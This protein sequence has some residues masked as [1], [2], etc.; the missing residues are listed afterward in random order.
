MAYFQNPFQS[1][2]RGSWVLGDR[3]YSLTFVCPPNTGRSNE[4]VVSWN[5][6]SGTT[7]NLSGND[8]DG[9][10]KNILNIRMSVDSTFKHW[11]NLSINLT[12]NTH[13]NLNPAPNSSAITPAQIVSILNA[14]PNFSSYFKATLENSSVSQSQFKNRIG[15]RMNYESTRMKFFIINGQ[16]EE[17][18]Q[19]NNRAGVAQL[20]LY[21]SRCKIWGG[22][23]TKPSD[24]SYALVLLDPSNVGGTSDVDNNVIDRAV[25]LKGNS[26]GLDSSTILADWELL[27]GRG[28]KLFTFRKNTVDVSDRITQVIEY[29]AGA[30]PG[31]LARKIQYVYAGSNKNPSQSTEIPYVIQS[32]DLINP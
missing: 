17:V 9:N 8:A 25:D 14:D 6:P 18:L 16:A 10:P 31:D 27:R 3:Q 15:I 21:F 11:G 32:N 28:S 5:E 29:P 26:L 4:F 22:D 13:A 1:E 24:E 2:F 7:F 12:D 20:P 19:F 30:L 23:L